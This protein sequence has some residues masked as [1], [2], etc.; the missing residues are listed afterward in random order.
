LED[1]VQMN[2]KADELN[3]VWLTDMSEL[4]TPQGKLYISSIIDL[5]SRFLVGWSVREDASV[6]GPLA[7]LRMG[8]EGLN[9]TGRAPSR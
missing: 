6:A 7:A 9:R 8:R 4:E 2:F 5:C 3:E 1:K